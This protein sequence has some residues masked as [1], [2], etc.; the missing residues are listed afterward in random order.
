MDLSMKASWIAALILLLAPPW[1]DAIVV[2]PADALLAVFAIAA[3]FGGLLVALG[4]K[5]IPLRIK[6][7]RDTSVMVMEGS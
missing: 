2:G 3:A 1:P 4:L 6:A 5:F 7:L